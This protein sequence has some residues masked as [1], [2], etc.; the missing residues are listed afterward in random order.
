MWITYFP[1]IA[2]RKQ[3]EALCRAIEQSD[4]LQLYVCN[5]SQYGIAGPNPWPQELVDRLHR[6][7]WQSATRKKGVLLAVCSARIPRLVGDR[8]WIRVLPRD[9]AQMLA[10]FLPN[11]DPF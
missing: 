9:L 3:R 7:S 6:A 1:E 10:S 11:K 8:T 2:T 4:D 5:T